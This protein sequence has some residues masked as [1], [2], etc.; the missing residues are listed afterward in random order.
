MKMGSP[1]CI[2]TGGQFPLLEFAQIIQPNFQLKAVDF[3]NMNV[4]HPFVKISTVCIICCIVN[5][6]KSYNS[7]FL[8]VP[9]CE[10][11]SARV[12]KTDHQKDQ[13]LISSSK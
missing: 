6:F 4:S 3:Y 10:K 5:R 7:L 9:S 8:K 1:F 13:K 11:K 2:I 12:V